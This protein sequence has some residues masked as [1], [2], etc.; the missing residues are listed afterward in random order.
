MSRELCN[1]RNKDF[2]LHY[3]NGLCCCVVESPGSY[4]AN[5]N[6]AFVSR[7][8]SRRGEHRLLIELGSFEV[9]PPFALA[10]GSGRSEAIH[11]K[12]VI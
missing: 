3:K 8:R 4:V 7:C 5:A 11:S 9:L 12:C 1:G 6:L 10:A 2:Q